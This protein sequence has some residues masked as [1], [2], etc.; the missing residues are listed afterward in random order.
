MAETW[1]GWVLYTAENGHK[2]HYNHLTHESRW[3]VDH[4]IEDQRAEVR[5]D[6]NV[7][8][9]TRRYPHFQTRLR[10][11]R[12]PSPGRRVVLLLSPWNGSLSVLDKCA[13]CVIG[14]PPDE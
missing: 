10:T 6:P 3:A 13:V 1:D 14:R 11:N 9:L 7:V 4:H 2:Y 12:S 8:A 5:L